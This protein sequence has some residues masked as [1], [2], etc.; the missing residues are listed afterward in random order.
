MRGL[1]QVIHRDETM[2]LV[3]TIPSPLANADVSTA[4]QT[5]ALVGQISVMYCRLWTSLIHGL[6]RECDI[7]IEQVIVRQFQFLRKGLDI[8]RR[9]LD[10]SLDWNS[11]L[12]NIR[13]NSHFWTR[14][15]SRLS[16][17]SSEIGYQ[18]ALFDRNCSGSLRS[19]PNKHTIVA[20]NITKHSS[21]SFV[22]HLM[23]QGCCHRFRTT[24]ILSTKSWIGRHRFTD[25]CLSRVLDD[26]IPAVT[27]NE[28]LP[29]QYRQLPY[30]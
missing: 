26:L 19:D 9:G 7:S 17:E 5:L 10:L 20:E 16:L 11:W 1:D 25:L 2:T 15:T 21:L 12:P 24:T 27:S 8:Q 23:A 22:F 18:T 13:R 29:F 30:F 14:F 4:I 3:S 28:R 6:T